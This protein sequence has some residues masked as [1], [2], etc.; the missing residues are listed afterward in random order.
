MNFRP[1]TNMTVYLTIILASVAESAFY[2]KFGSLRFSHNFR[3]GFGAVIS[4]VYV[5][6]AALLDRIVFTAFSF[7]K[8]SLR[9]TC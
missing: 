5:K 2:C 4:I 1:L 3:N 9:R 8:R 7:L 6:K